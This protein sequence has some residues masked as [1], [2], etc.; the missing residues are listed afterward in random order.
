MLSTIII[1]F[2]VALAVAGLCVLYREL[3]AKPD[4]K[5]PAP[6]GPFSRGE[7]Y[8]FPRVRRFGV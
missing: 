8:I 7:L 2:A 5:L 1:I 4:P 6:A 3:A